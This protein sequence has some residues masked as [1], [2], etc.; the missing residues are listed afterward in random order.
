[1]AKHAKDKPNPERFKLLKSS[2]KR[3]DQDGVST[4]RYEINSVFKNALFTRIVVSYNETEMLK[5]VKT[6]NSTT[7][8]SNSTKVTV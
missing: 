5:I 2:D 6:T 4:V 1:M 7:T 3:I 8:A